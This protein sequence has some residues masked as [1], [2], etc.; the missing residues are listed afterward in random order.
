MLS[1]PFFSTVVRIQKERGHAVTS[2]GPYGFV[3]HPGYAGMIVFT[4]A[5]PLILNSLWALAPA[6][7]TVAATALRTALEDRMLQRE[8]DG[9]ADYSARV[10]YRLIPG[11]W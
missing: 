7:F 9:Y 4:V 10:R 2:R 6:F 1:N 11:L 8:L 3:R 5:M